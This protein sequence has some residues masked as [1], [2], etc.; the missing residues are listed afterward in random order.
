MNG[1]RNKKLSFTIDD[2]RPTIIAHIARKTQCETQREKENETECH[3]RQFLYQ[4][5]C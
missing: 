5:C 2:Q 4:F 1:S 3:Q